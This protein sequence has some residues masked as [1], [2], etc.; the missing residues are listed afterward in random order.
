MARAR[1]RT[2]ICGK[3]TSHAATIMH[4]D[5]TR[6]KS[7]AIRRS[8][9]NIQANFVSRSAILNDVAAS[10]SRNGPQLTKTLL[11]LGQYTNYT[12]LLCS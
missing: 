7:G 3:E 11:V 9:E 4:R 12:C 5:S 10:S 1:H 6:Y 2:R 8:N